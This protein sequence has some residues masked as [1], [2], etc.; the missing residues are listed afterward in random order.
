MFAG[1]HPLPN[2]FS[3]YLIFPFQF[4]DLHFQRVSFELSGLQRRL[5]LSNF[6]EAVLPISSCSKGVGFALFD[7]RAHSRA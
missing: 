7:A 2:Y 6:I 5:E 4:G 1:V 3:Q